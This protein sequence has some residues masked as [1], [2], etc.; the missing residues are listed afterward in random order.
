MYTTSQLT[1]CADVALVRTLIPIAQDYWGFSEK[2]KKNLKL[3]ARKISALYLQHSRQQRLQSPLVSAQGGAAVV[4]KHSIFL[5]AVRTILLLPGPMYLDLVQFRCI[6]I[7]ILVFRAWHIADQSAGKKTTHRKER[8][9]LLACVHFPWR[10]RS[11]KVWT[12][13][14]ICLSPCVCHVID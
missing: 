11:P 8:K 7:C 5:A 6:F 12:Q 4:S 3:E 2:K 9:S 10:L 14:G 13:E 1:L